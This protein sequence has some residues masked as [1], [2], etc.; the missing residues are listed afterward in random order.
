MTAKELRATARTHLKG[1]WGMAIL[2]GIVA[3]LLGAD[4]TFG[5]YYTSLSTASDTAQQTLEQ[6]QTLDP[7]ALASAAQDLPFLDISTVQI[8]PLITIL[9]IVAFLF[10]GAVALGWCLYNQNLNHDRPAEMK[11][12]FTYFNSFG[13][14]FLTN[15]LVG[16][17]TLL[18]TLLLIVPGIIMSFA[19]S[20]TFYILQENP[21]MKPMEAIRASKELMKGYKW[22]LFCLEFSFIG[23]ILLS[24]LTLGI[25]FV[26]LTPYMEQ[27]R[28]AFYNNLKAE[29]AALPTE[30]AVQA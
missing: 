15:L 19:Y 1:R 17:F 29:K 9:G 7:A 28:C 22:K 23:W 16:L 2:V 24:A 21:D 20:Q 4:S 12:L 11:D 25:G 10:G 26:F 14:A 13:K 3:S 8:S 6:T 30:P 18:W 5:T 27:A